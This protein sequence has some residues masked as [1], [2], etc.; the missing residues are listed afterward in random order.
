MEDKSHQDALFALKQARAAFNHGDRGLA[1]SWAS[2]AAQLAPDTEEPWLLLAAVTSPKGS[3]YYLQRALEANPESVQ[4][5]KGIVWAQRQIGLPTENLETAAN[6][7]LPPQESPTAFIEDTAQQKTDIQSSPGHKF[8]FVW[9]WVLPVFTLLLGIL[10]GFILPVDWVVFARGS[11]EP[12]LFTLFATSTPTASFTPSSTVTFTP[13]STGT[14]TPSPT[15]TLTM[16]PTFTVTATYTPTVTETATPTPTFTPT[17]IPTRTPIPPPP[18]LPGF[19]QVQLPQSYVEEYVASSDPVN[20][21]SGER[22]IDVDLT[23]QQVVAYKGEQAVKSFRVSTG[24]SNHPTVTGQFNIYVKYRYD[25]MSGPGYNLKDVPYVM[26][27]Y[28]GY[29]LHG[30]YWHSNFGTPMSHGCVNM[31]TSDAAWLYSWAS[32]GTLVNVHY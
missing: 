18:P 24:T 30:T 5:R 9:S 22:W 19:P 10:I 6:P 11:S 27:F 15:S 25:D 1:F 7:E 28:K 23:N 14:L 12:K 31:V 13:T 20:P 16:A 29:S 17:S 3:L 21:G 2:K 4:A 32:E 8:K 26:Y